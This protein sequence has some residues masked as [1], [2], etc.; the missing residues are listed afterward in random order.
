VFQPLVFSGTKISL[1]TYQ[2]T[3]KIDVGSGTWSP[4]P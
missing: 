1:P 2:T 4:S 3:W